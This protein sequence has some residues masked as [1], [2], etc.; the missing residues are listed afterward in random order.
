MRL[1]REFARYVVPSV[2]AFALSGVYAVTDGFFVG[3]ALGDEAL[4]AINIAYPLTAFLQAAGTGIGMGGAIQYAIQTG[5]GREEEGRQYF[6]A[7]VALLLAASALLMGLYL[8]QAP[9]LL[10]LFGAQGEILELGWQYIRCISLGAFF[11][12]LATGLVPFLR[13]LGGTVAAMASMIAGFVTN[14]VLDYLFVWVL[15]WGMTGAAA[16]TAIGQAVTFLVCALALAHRR[17]RPQ[18]R[19]GG[20]GG[21]LMARVLLVGLSPF[22]LTFSPNITLILI[23]KSAAIFGGEFAVMVYAPISYLSSVILLLLQGVSDG[24]QPLLSLAYGRGEEEKARKV[25]NLALLCALALGAA[26][27]FLLYLLRGQTALLFGASPAVAEEAGRVLPIF[28]SGYLFLAVSRV[29]TAYLYATGQ[30]RRAYLLIYGEPI[31][32]AAL[33]LLLPPALGVAGTWWAIPL[34]EIFTAL[35]SLWFLRRERPLAPA[36]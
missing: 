3:N 23:N 31:S 15:P 9:A 11:Q 30:N 20:R 35:L 7:S 24:C 2:L 33:L 1:Y 26:C 34:S 21:R 8:W 17:A 5:G 12:I 18:F 14:L 19:F 6:G 13:N 16:A 36:R 25:R 4:A 32:L 27:M 22:G 10:G 29:V 28:L